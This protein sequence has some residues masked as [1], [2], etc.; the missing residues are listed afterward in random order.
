MKKQGWNLKSESKIN[1][2]ARDSKEAHSARNTGDHTSSQAITTHLKG[3]FLIVV[4]DKRFCFLSKI[5]LL[6]HNEMCSWLAIQAHQ[7]D[8]NNFSSNDWNI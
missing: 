5:R 7:V 8:E 3:Q 6:V 1:W 2:Q 4:K